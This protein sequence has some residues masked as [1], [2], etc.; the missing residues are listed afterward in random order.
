MFSVWNNNN[1]KN[2]NQYST[3]AVIL[4]QFS[5]GTLL[6]ASNISL[7]A[8][9]MMGKSTKWYSSLIGMS[10]GGDCKFAIT[11]SHIKFNI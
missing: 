7:F 5:N 11:K 6:N 9:G 3:V 1:N 10:L 8:N 4:T 2:H